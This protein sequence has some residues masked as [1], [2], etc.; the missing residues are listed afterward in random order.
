ML[1][2]VVFERLTASSTAN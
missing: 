1:K 2:L